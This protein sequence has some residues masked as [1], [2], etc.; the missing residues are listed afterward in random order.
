VSVGTG[1]ERGFR[2][3]ISSSAVFEAVQYSI[4]VIGGE[5]ERD[6]ERL[7]EIQRD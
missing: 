4:G 2:V 6:T 1:E 3:I 5:I 7:R